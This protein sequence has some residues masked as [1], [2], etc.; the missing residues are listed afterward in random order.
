GATHLEDC[1]GMKEGYKNSDLSAVAKPDF[2]SSI[3]AILECYLG[4]K[5]FFPVVSA[6][7]AKPTQRLGAEESKEETLVQEV[8]LSFCTL[9]PIEGY[10]RFNAPF[11]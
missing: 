1:F 10:K 5:A 7:K 11:V 8:G 9:A 3:L 2:Q 4:P 6:D